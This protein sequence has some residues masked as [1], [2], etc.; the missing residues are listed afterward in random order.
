[1]K[2]AIGYRF[3]CDQRLISVIDA[4]V[5]KKKSYSNFKPARLIGWTESKMGLNVMDNL[6]KL[7]YVGSPRILYCAP[8]ESVNKPPSKPTSKLSS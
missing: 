1:M 6:S 4:A 7:F 5:R 3:I 2:P 8:E